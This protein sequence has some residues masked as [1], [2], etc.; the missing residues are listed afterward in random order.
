MD[1]EGVNP[2]RDVLIENGNY[3][4]TTITPDKYPA[5][6]ESF[7]AMGYHFIG[8][9]ENEIKQTSPGAWEKFVMFPISTN[10]VP[11]I[12]NSPLKMDDAVYRNGKAIRYISLV[13]PS[14][15]D[16]IGSTFMNDWNIKNSDEILLNL[17]NTNRA[18][19]W[20]ISLWGTESE[21]ENILIPKTM[22]N[23]LLL[24]NTTSKNPKPFII[25][26]KYGKIFN[27]SGKNGDEIS[28][29]EYTKD[30]KFLNRRITI[31]DAE[32]LKL[33]EKISG[34]ITKYK[35]Q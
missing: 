16:S 15:Q 1:S 13:L 7:L 29:F 34:I 30:L 27:I 5:V 20:I 28:I 2:L 21:I 35:I 14:V 18:D 23:T 9:S 17:S 4:G 26:K 19:L 32:N 6:F 11:K 10:L 33:S 25:S 31:L 24:L 22:G 3:L 8:L 12:N